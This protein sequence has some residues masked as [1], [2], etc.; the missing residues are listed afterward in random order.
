MI[1]WQMVVNTR[2]PEEWSGID[3]FFAADLAVATIALR[4]ARLRLAN[5]DPVTIGPRGGSQINPLVPV[6]SSL[7]NQTLR[8]S[9]R[10]RLGA[11]DVG[12]EDNITTAAA[13]KRKKEAE[14]REK[15]AA[16]D[17]E[18]ILRPRPTAVQ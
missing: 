3:E 5:E 15:M 16:D 10:L 7:V 1:V 8:L 4:N 6:I 11:L 18:L 17:S 13:R 9:A 2:A 14:A 12:D